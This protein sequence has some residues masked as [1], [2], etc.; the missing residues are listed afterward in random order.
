MSL[1]FNELVYKILSLIVIDL[2]LDLILSGHI[3][4]LVYV[5]DCVGNQGDRGPTSVL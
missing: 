1:P 2:I 4:G 5:K 3:L